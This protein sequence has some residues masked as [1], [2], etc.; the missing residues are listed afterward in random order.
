M[1]GTAASNAWSSRTSLI[2]FAPFL[3]RIAL[4]DES[5]GVREPIGQITPMAGRIG[6][7]MNI[8]LDSVT[9]FG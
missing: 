4:P 5:T 8:F 3:E 9:L 6:P 7:N 1:T 2:F